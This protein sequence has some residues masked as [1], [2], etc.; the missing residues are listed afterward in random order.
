MIGKEI[1]DAIAPIVMW[2]AIIGGVLT[3]LGLIYWRIRRGA[4]KEERGAM[5]AEGQKEERDARK[6]IKDR[7]AEMRRDLLAR[8]RGGGVPHD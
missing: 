5:V 2:G 8:A 7:A 6:S 3:L 4:K 1:A